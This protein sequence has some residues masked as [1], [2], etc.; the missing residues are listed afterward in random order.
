[1]S[2][3]YLISLSLFLTAFFISPT[4]IEASQIF[5]DGFE[6]RDMSATNSYGFSWAANNRTSI[7]TMDPED[8]SV[9][10]YNNGAVY[11]IA[12]PTKDWYAKN[13]DYSLRFRYPAGEAWAEQRFGLGIAY[14]ELW[15]NYWL[16]VPNN[17]NHTAGTGSNNKFFAIWSDAYSGPTGVNVVWE[18]RPINEGSSQIY[19]KY[20]K[21]NEGVGGDNQYTPF[22]SVPADRGRWM[23]V[24]LHIKL[25]SAVDAND[26]IIETLRRWDGDS[27][28]TQLHYADNINIYPA[29]G[30]HGFISGYILGWAN[31]AYA[32]ETEWLMDDFTLSVTNPLIDSTAPLSPRGLSIY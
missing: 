25:A 30:P 15:I 18:T 24:L 29:S 20:N 5:F 32:E 27:E 23:Q 13:G 12:T 14:P 11:T 31:G 8:G 28:Y 21:P 1:M 3:P 26:G 7:V 16:K 10:V 22:I 9:A 4:K 2:K 6:S 17:F 19:F